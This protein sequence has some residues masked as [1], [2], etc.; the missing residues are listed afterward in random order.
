[1][2]PPVER[3]DPPLRDDVPEPDD[4]PDDERE[5]PLLEPLLLG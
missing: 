3:R 2:P 4:V 1:V 5:L